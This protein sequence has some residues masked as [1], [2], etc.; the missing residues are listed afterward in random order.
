M[1]V[2][3]HHLVIVGCGKSKLPYSAPAADLYVGGLFKAARRY[4]ETFGTYWV[5]ASAKH[6]LVS[7]S[8]ILEPYNETMAD[9]D[10]DHTAQWGHLAKC[11]L[12]AVFLAMGVGEVRGNWVDVP[13]VTILAGEAYVA[14]MLKY[15]FLRKYPVDVPLRSKGIGQRIK[16]LKEQVATVSKG[17]T[18]CC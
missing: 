18:P 9:R 14:P 6:G 15:T 2:D 10:K 13:R 3:R 12:I 17:V 8:K 4:A 1:A 7:P 16:W 11:D 5:I